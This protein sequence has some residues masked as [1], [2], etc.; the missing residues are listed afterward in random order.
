[1]VMSEANVHAGGKVL[2]GSGNDHEPHLPRRKPDRGKH[3]AAHSN[4]TAD[5]QREVVSARSIRLRFGAR[6]ASTGSGRSSPRS[7]LRRDSSSALLCETLLMRDC[8]WNMV[9][10]FIRNAG[11]PSRQSKS[12]RPNRRWLVHGAADRSPSFL[13]VAH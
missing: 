5:G 1:M 13:T 8:S 4:Q 12:G 9:P 10:D 7:L 3:L 11:S 6:D 2:S